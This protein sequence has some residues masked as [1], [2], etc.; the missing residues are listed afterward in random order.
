[1]SEEK[2][3][4]K[5]GD[6]TII[7]LFTKTK[8]D[9]V[10]PHFWVCK[11][12][13]GCEFDCQWC[14]LNGTYRMKKDKKKVLIGKKP[15]YKEPAKVLKHVTRAME[16]IPGPNMY[17]AGELADGLLFP[18]MLEQNVVPVFKQHYKKTGNKLLILTKSKKIAPL[19]GW[20]A[21]DCIVVAFSVNAAHVSE[22]WEIDAP[23]PWERLEAAKK[24]RDYGYPVRLRID[25]MVPV[26][27]W[28]VGYRELVDKIMKYVPDAEVITLGSLRMT[29]NPNL[30][31][32]IRL[33]KDTSY[34]DSLRPAKQSRVLVRLYS[35]SIF[36][37]QTWG[38]KFCRLLGIKI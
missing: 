31:T 29:V 30:K 8:G 37:P 18:W 35:A 1:M 24:V 38:V 33:D 15:T 2:K 32:C 21:Q 28:E 25:P 26:S 22:R 11:P 34:T 20:K 13:N 27:N 6:G 5:I 14:Y 23:H 16:E 10:C 9:I 19:F 36:T 3:I 17:N 12:F 4:T 7:E